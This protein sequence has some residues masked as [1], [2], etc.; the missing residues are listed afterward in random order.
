MLVLFNSPGAG[1]DATG[2]ANTFVGNVEGDSSIRVIRLFSLR[3]APY[4]TYKC[5]GTTGNYSGG[6]LRGFVTG[7]RSTSTMVITAPIC[8]LSFPTPVGTLFSHFRQ[9]CRTRFEEG[10]TRPVAGRGGTLLLMATKSSR[11]SKCGVVRGR[12]GLSFS[13]VGARL[14]N[15]MLTGSASGNNIGRSSL[16]HTFRLSGVVCNWGDTT[17]Q[18]F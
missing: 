14:I 4:G 9:C 3:P 5:Y 1:N 10:V 17:F 13:I 11:S 16:H 7:L 18:H 15:N 6:S 12:I 8:G 2:L